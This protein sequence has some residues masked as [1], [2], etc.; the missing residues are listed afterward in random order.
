MTHTELVERAARWLK[1][2]LR[3]TIVLKEEGSCIV[4]PPWETGEI[5]DAIGWRRDGWSILIECKTPLSDFY[6]DK[7]KPFR[8]DNRGVGQERWYMTPP[9][10]L[11]PAQLKD[12]WG[13]AEAH[14]R[15][16]RRVVTADR[17]PLHGPV[18]RIWMAPRPE[19][20]KYNKRWRTGWWRPLRKEP[21]DHTF[22]KERMCYEIPLLVAAMNRARL[23][24]MP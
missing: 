21:A 20:V 17:R 3:C 9:G 24:T 19:W 10:I 22:I 18:Q 2:T 23:R 7:Q 4:T 13:L 6:S 1:N 14:K 5:P 12:G 16:V 8:K 15:I 11:K